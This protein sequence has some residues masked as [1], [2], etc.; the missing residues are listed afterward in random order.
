MLLNLLLSLFS[1]N[2]LLNHICIIMYVLYVTYVTGNFI[3][4]AFCKM[5][6]L[7]RHFIR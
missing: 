4:Q 7:F 5:P 2:S 6:E 1:V 3:I